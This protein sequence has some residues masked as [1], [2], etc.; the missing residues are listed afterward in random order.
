MP[1]SRRLLFTSEHSLADPA[2]GAALSATETLS[3]LASR[4][5]QPAVLCGSKTDGILSPLR[6]LPLTLDTLGHPDIHFRQLNGGEDNPNTRAALLIALLHHE[7]QT[8]PP[9]LLLTFGGRW[10]GRAILATARAFGIPTAFWLR[11]TLYANPDLFNP[12]IPGRAGGVTGGSIVPSVF[13]SK[14]YRQTLNLQTEV[15]YPPVT[16]DRVR[17]YVRQ[18]RYV[19]LISPLPEKG[20]FFISRVISELSRQRDDIE[21]LIVEGR[22]DAAWLDR[23]GL[24]ILSLPN[25][26]VLRGKTADPRDFLAVTRILLMPSVWHE[27]FGRS[28]LEAMINGIPVVASDRGAL[29]ETLGNG[30][31]V[32]PIPPR[33]QPNTALLATPQEAIPWVNAIIR[34]WDEEE[35]YRAISRMATASAARFDP[36]VMA[37]HAAQILTQ[38]AATPVPPTNLSLEQILTTSGYPGNP[39][40]AA[41]DAENAIQRLQ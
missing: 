4:D 33:I 25:V 31:V 11:N 34:L 26:K 13:A 16:R 1:T 15:V 32:L 18:P 40:Q 12:N 29:P 8:T 36:G 5:W 14:Y 7:L 23:T 2:S 41:K 37:D 27:T 39:T 19:T 6:T 24:S 17:C 20:I 28:A 10:V 38:F 30:G 9:D 35:H 3:Q 22:G 21:F